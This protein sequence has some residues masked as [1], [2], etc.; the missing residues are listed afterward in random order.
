MDKPT[1]FVLGN[2]EKQITPDERQDKEQ[3]VTCP[4]KRRSYHIGLP[5]GSDSGLCHLL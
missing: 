5:K 4:K 3:Q 1:L 2:S